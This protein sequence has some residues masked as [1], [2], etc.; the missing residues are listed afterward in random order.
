MKFIGTR[1]VGYVGFEDVLNPRYHPDPK[2]SNIGPYI[3]EILSSKPAPRNARP[4]LACPRTQR[5]ELNCQIQNLHVPTL[6]P[7]AQVMN[8]EP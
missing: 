2:Y 8:P 3:T 7:E 1:F 4:Q 6:N 5:L